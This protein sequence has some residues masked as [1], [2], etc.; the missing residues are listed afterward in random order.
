MGFGFSLLEP[1]I[2]RTAS[3]KSYFGSHRAKVRE[4]PFF[5]SLLPLILLEVG[6]ARVERGKRA[7]TVSR[8][9]V[10]GFGILAGPCP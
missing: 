8:T 1:A 10:L 2:V 6:R 3:T 7:K 9:W 5:S 4:K